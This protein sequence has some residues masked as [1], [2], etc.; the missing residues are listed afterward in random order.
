MCSR[1]TGI[2]PAWGSSAFGVVVTEFAD[3]TVTILHAEEYHR[4][5]YNE[6]LSKS[7]GLIS[8]YQVDKVYI[9]GA[10]PSLIRSLKLQIGEDP[11]YDK[12]IARY[13]AQLGT[14]EVSAAGVGLDNWI[15][16]A[17]TMCQIDSTVDS[18]TNKKLQLSAR[19]KIREGKLEGFKR[20]AAVCISH[21]KEKDPGTLQYDWFLNSDNTE[22]E[23]R[24]TYESSEALLA[25]RN[26]LVNL[27][28]YFLSNT[29]QIIL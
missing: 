1:S 12:V 23:I 20:Q 13:K 3:G 15:A 25:H 4:P 7:Y 21:V 2:D 27:S 11:D 24:E 18:M 28:E 26:N 6:K 8:K 17:L 5:D 14:G 19:M 10:N 16:D 9:D 22:W 29:V